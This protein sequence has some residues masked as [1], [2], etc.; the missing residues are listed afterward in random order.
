MAWT[1]SEVMGLVWLATPTQ[2][3][4]DVLLIG[5]APQGV[6][7]VWGQDLFLGSARS[8]SQVL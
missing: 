3:R 5:K 8:R 6:S 2:T 4:Q 1:I 7:L